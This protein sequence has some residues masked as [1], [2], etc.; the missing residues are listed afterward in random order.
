MALLPACRGAVHRQCRLPGG[1]QNPAF[2]TKPDITWTLVERAVAAGIAFK[3][4]IADSADGDNPFFADT[5][6][7]YVLPYVLAHSGTASC[8]R[9][10]IELA[11]S[12][13]DAAAEL[14]ARQ[15][16]PIVR[17]LRNCHTQQ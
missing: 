10:P 1:Q 4:I 14:P 15:W 5:L 3:A 16:R 17:R 13:R 8:G 9:A 6:T 7:E 12:L 11:H 2:H